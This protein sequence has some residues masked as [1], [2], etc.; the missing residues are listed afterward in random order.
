MDNATH[1]LLHCLSWA[2]ERENLFVAFSLDLDL[3]R[4]YTHVIE[5]I[6]GS[7]DAW[8]AFANFCEVVI[9]RKK[10]EKEREREQTIG[11]RPIDVIPT[12]IDKLLNTVY[13][14]VKAVAFPRFKVDDSIRM[15]KF[16]TIFEKGYTLNWTTEVV[17]L[18]LKSSKY[19][20]LI[21]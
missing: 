3:D 1:T 17:Q 4:K 11:M 20:K 7:S 2:V 6:V 10:M 18:I 8:T 15:S 19:R 21:L 14:S 9:K 13:S 5:A 16:K 12:I